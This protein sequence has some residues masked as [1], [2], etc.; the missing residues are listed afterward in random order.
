MDLFYLDVTRACL[1]K[2]FNIGVASVTHV[3]NKNRTGNGKSSILEALN[4]H[5][6]WDRSL[7]KEF[8]LKEKSSF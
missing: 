5:T 2:C 4:C 7:R 3:R 8:V 6:I 1:L